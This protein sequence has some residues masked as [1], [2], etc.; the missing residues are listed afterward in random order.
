[1]A[2]APAE[3]CYIGWLATPASDCAVPTGRT[4]IWLNQPNLIHSAQHSILAYQ[5]DDQC[6]SQSP[7]SANS[8]FSGF[9][10]DLSLA[11]DSPGSF[12]EGL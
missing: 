8:G 3:L 11:A 4:R 2:F 9:V 12:R 7:S 10:I 6:Q 1:M 5:P